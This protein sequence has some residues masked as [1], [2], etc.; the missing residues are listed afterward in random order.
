M[1]RRLAFQYLFLYD[2]NNGDCESVQ[3]FMQ[4]QSDDEEIRLFSY[5]LVNNYIDN[6]EKVDSILAE[7]VKN[8]SFNRIAS[9]EKNVL[10]L[11][12]AEI[13]VEGTPFKVVINEALKLAKK[14]GSKDSHKFV[15]GILDSLAKDMNKC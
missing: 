1:S 15:N 8:Y 10:R 2:M 7:K 6:R 4:D 14:F 9:V 3:E 11:A 12:T 13:E 5:K